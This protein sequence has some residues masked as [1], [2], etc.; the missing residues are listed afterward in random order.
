MDSTRDSSIISF[1]LSHIERAKRF[2]FW[3]DEGS[4]VHR[5][6]ESS[7]INRD[8]LFVNCQV[9][10][11]EEMVTGRMS[12]SIQAYERTQKMARSDCI[13]SFLL[14]LVE[15]GSVVY[16]S[17]SG[18]FCARQ[19]DILLIDQDESSSSHWSAHHQIYVTIPRIPNQMTGRMPAGT[20]H[21]PASNASALILA[22]YLRLFWKHCSMQSLEEN[23]K[24]MK[25]LAC[26]THIYF[27]KPGLELESA[28][29][30]E[31]DDSLFSII[32]KW[33]HENLHRQD[34]CPEEI[35]ST[36]YLSRSSL[37]SLFQS[38]G[39]VRSYLQTARLERAR[40]ILSS[41]KNTLLVSEVANRLGFRSVSSFSRAFANRWGVS[42]REFRK[43][44]D[45]TD[46]LA[47]FE[48]EMKA[49]HAD[50]MRR[51]A[52]EYYKTVQGSKGRITDSAN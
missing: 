32:E 26:L 11:L 49:S 23:V 15:S 4:L 29:L 33:I 37:Y 36:F 31:E 42:P 17:R 41:P 24:L 48:S 28:S 13:D 20:Q 18:S 38:H 5:P 25:G 40:K 39:G 6:V 22:Q 8:A 46:K 44:T 27:C 34:L 45:Q 52:V 30:H 47:H 9:A 7:I 50:T 21:L 14:T 43:R 51:H 1:D 16:T 35:C 2:E 3:H 10:L 19:G 12:G